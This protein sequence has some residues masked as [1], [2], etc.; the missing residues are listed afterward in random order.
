MPRLSGERIGKMLS[1]Y[2]PSGEMVTVAVGHVVNV[3]ITGAS[4]IWSQ[5]IKVKSVS[6]P[7][8]PTGA[9]VISGV[10]TTEEVSG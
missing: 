1:F 10:V 2:V 9:K 8:H 5:N 3:N 6:L 4:E 7:P